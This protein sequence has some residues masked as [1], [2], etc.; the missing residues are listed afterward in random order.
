MAEINPGTAQNVDPPWW[1]KGKLS[2]V[3]FSMGQGDCCVI[4]L[5]DGRHVMIDCG[6]KAYEE[7]G[8]EEVP[9]LLKSKDVLGAAGSSVN[10]IEALVLTHSDKDHYNRV[11]ELLAGLTV[12][13]VYFSEPVLGKDIL[14]RAPYLKG[15]LQSYKENSVNNTIYNNLGVEELCGV[16][17]RASA[18]YIM[19][20]RWEPP[21]NDKNHKADR[22]VYTKP[23]DVFLPIVTDVNN[24]F[25]VSILAGNVSKGG[26]DKS[27]DEINPA[28]IVTL[29]EANLQINLLGQAQAFKILIC[30]DAT[31]STEAYLLKHHA[32]K[33]ANLTLLQVPHHGSDTSST[34]DFIV[35]TRPKA[36][37]I[38]VQKDEA[39]HNLPKAASVRPYEIGGFIGTTTDSRTISYWRPKEK[40]EIEAHRK[41]WD[42]EGI[43]YE[44]VLK[45]GRLKRC[46]REMP[47]NFG[48]KVL[49]G[50]HQTGNSEAI[51]ILYEMKTKKKIY[52]TGTQQ[53]CWFLYP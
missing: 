19:V 38:S 1:K 12:K 50:F 43:E 41:L 25:S 10:T 51:Y 34:A 13:K 28:S 3:F 4:T 39:T 32:D 40:K 26:E 30:G 53:H 44:K 37:I 21:F 35:H 16:T 18:N 2:L 8:I 27:A 24:Q 9:G 7:E 20:D 33:L 49:D 17:T 36:I 47:D 6:T 46:V 14:Q 48:V 52:Q 42:T 11:T 45:D 5:P 31:S 15:P 22:L 29:I 23:S